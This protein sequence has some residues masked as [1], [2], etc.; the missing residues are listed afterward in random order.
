MQT[1]RNANEQITLNF[2]LREP[3]GN[4]CTNIYAV[5]KIDGK[6][7]KMPIGLKINSWQWDKKK[8]RP[9]LN[10]IVSEEEKE[11][12]MNVLTKINEINF[13]FSE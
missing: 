1:L 11:N 13:A 6:Q 12:A 2:N 5:V 8:Q 3:K 7:I 9:H 10:Y 4:K